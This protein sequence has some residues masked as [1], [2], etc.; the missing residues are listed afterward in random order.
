MRQFGQIAVMMTNVDR[1]QS[2]MFLII[3]SVSSVYRYGAFTGTG[4]L[5][6]RGVYRYGAFTGTGRLPVRGVYRYGATIL[7]SYVPR[8][9]ALA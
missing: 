7:V 8:E 9:R 5:P 2:P 6:V 3:S 1:S 4:R